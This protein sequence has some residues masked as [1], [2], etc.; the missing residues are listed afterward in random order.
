MLNVR[1]ERYA[2]VSIV[3]VNNVSESDYSS[4]TLKKKKITYVDML[5]VPHTR[6]LHL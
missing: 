3:C 4:I 1:N 5:S 6:L 2:F